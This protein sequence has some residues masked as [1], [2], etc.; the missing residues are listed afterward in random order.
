MQEKDNKAQK[1][2]KKI[3]EKYTKL[4]QQPTFG[5]QLNM[6]IRDREI[7]RLFL[8]IILCPILTEMTR[9]AGEELDNDSDEKK[10]VLEPSMNSSALLVAKSKNEVDSSSRAIFLR[11]PTQL[12]QED[13]ELIEQRVEIK[14]NLYFV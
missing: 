3:Q 12:T 2:G 1:K 9:I 10:Y 14:V 7:C 6:M 13:L 4:H 8:I 11:P 5:C